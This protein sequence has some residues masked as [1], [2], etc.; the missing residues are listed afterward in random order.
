MP[1]Q[2]DGQRGSLEMWNKKVA[3]LRGTFAGE[4]FS[5][6]L[7]AL[8]RFIGVF[9]ENCM[10][11]RKNRLKLPFSCMYAKSNDTRGNVRSD[12]YE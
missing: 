9:N 7:F 2:V 3:L 4:S 10:F 5:Y 8:F 1:H 11:R 12:M 6:V